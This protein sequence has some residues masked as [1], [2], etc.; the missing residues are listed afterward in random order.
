M[1][2]RQKWGLSVVKELERI[3]DADGE[4]ADSRLLAR[5]QHTTAAIMELDNKVKGGLESIGVASKPVEITV[6]SNRVHIQ[7]E[8]MA[9][10]LED[11]LQAI[12]VRADELEEYGA[13]NDDAQII[14]LGAYYRALVESI[15]VNPAIFPPAEPASAKAGS[16]DEINRAM[17]RRELIGG[18]AMAAA[19]VAGI[20]G[21]VVSQKA[22]A[23]GADPGT[24]ALA[25]RFEAWTAQ[26]VVDAK[27][28]YAQII[29]Q[30]NNIQSLFNA[31]NTVNNAIIGGFDSLLSFTNE[32]K[33]KDLVA[34][35][36]AADQQMRMMQQ[37]ERIKAQQGSKSASG[38]CVNDSA[39]IVDDK[40]KASVVQA[41]SVVSA[42]RVE[43]KIFNRPGDPGV[44]INH[45][46]RS[47]EIIIDMQQKNVDAFNAGG[48]SAAPIKTDD[49]SLKNSQKSFSKLVA[50]PVDMIY[51][52]L[53]L[54]ADTAQ[55]KAYV[56]AATTRIARRSMAEAA[57]ARITQ[58]NVRDPNAYAYIHQNL[59]SLIRDTPPSQYD[60]AG[61]P[62]ESIIDQRLKGHA[63][64]LIKQL[65]E[66]AGQDKGVSATESLEF[67]VLAKS[68]TSFYEFVR[69]SGFSPTPL[70]REVIEQNSV[71]LKLQ[72]E[73]YK[74][75]KETN[76]LLS[77]ILVELQ[78][79][80][81]RIEKL[82]QMKR[83]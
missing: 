77:T 14:M 16:K 2:A 64:K 8:K 81:D 78:D 53:A 79:S 24:A 32:N 20:G 25:T 3:V 40:L 35:M 33:M 74:A 19:L 18:G 1:T 38:A 65:E 75:S 37:N 70:I 45:V 48:L 67:Q 66:M 7:L 73:M 76:A 39:S 56:A 36:T 13:T 59:K 55:G 61:K 42:K 82:N 5:L 6:S 68:N 46:N 34:N 50:E 29:E 26:W 43:D 9:A 30:I 71:A 60:S 69:S 4:C 57:M 31:L 15:R 83:G 72:L 17:K 10:L 49:R 27:S 41:G 62:V 52:D 63:E 12:L 23:F 80:P 22:Q 58:S 51:G 28:K 44:E 54:A 47:S 11:A 21:M